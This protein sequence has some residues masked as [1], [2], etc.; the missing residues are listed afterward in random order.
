MTDR[1]VITSTDFSNTNYAAITAGSRGQGDPA[2]SKCGN[3]NQDCDVGE[4]TMDDVT[5][6]NVET[7]LATVVD[8]E[9]LLPCLTSL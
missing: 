1:H 6:S 3:S 4:F 2:Y 9:Q 8:R 5:F 7:H